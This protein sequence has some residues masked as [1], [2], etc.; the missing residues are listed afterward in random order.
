[1]TPEKLKNILEAVLLSADHPLTVIQ[2]DTLFESDE[3]RPTRDEVRKTLQEMEVAYSESGFELK[4]VA[5]GYR[6]QVK[7][8]FAPWVGRLWEE[9][10]ARYTRA[11]LET[12]ALIAYRQP[13]TRGEIEDVRG[14]SVSSNIIRTLQERDW[15][16]VLGHKDVPG[17]PALYGTTREFLDYFNLKSLDELPSL[18]ELKDLDHIYPELALEEGFTADENTEAKVE[19]ESEIADEMV[20]DAAVSE[21]VSEGSSESEAINAEAVETDAEETEVIEDALDEQTEESALVNE[22]DD[23]TTVDQQ[24]DNEQPDEESLDTDN[25]D[26]D[27]GAD[28]EQALDDHADDDG[29]DSDDTD[30]VNKTTTAASM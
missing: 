23:D 28:T 25:A 26:A 18:A 3:D 10:P 14:V 12:M 7:Q 5:T 2:L 24:A 11:L 19:G 4:Q 21:D 17:K 9:K 8:E 20:D 30:G 16:K 22:S 29:S 15:I 6:L 1:M 13:V 27:A